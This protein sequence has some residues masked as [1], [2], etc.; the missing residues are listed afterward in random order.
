VTVDIDGEEP[1]TTITVIEAPN[2][3]EKQAYV[4]VKPKKKSVK[5]V[6][7]N[8]EDEYIKQL[9]EAEIPKT[10]L[11]QFEKPEFEQ[12]KKSIKPDS[13]E[14]KPKKKKEVENRNTD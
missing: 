9:L 1:E 12:R 5:K 11:E 8:D 13:D 3:V 2:E 10:E 6:K 4:Q 7:K 14:E